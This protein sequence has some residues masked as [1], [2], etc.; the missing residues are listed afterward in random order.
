MVEEQVPARGVTD[1]R[2]LAAMRR[3]PRHLFVDEALRDQAYGD[4]PLPI[5]DGQTISQP[6][7]VGAHDRA[8]GARRAARRCSRS[9]R[10]SGYQAAVLAELAARVCTVERMPRLADAGPADAWRHWGITTCGCG[11]RTARW[12]AGRGPVRPHPGGGGRTERASAAVRAAR[13]GRAH[14]DAGGRRHQPGALARREGQWRDAHER[15][16]RV[17][18]RQA[19]GKVRVG[20]LRRH[21]RT[22]FEDARRSAGRSA[23]W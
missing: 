18:V 23:A 11:R 8:A 12:V 13:R 3:V 5:G 6:F 22:G 20:A 7:I 14:G 10:A 16:F 17:H 4:H 9:A 21:G 1:A 2:V 19:R 15:A